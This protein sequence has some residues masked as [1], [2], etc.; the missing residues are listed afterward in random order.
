[1][2]KFFGYDFEGCFL[3]IAEENQQ[4]T[5]LRFGKSDLCNA[6][7]RETAFLTFVAQQLSE[8]FS[9]KRK[10]FD[11]PL[12]LEGTDFQ[13]KVW[14]ALLSIPYGETCSYKQIAEKVGC[15]KGC[16]A[17]GMA[18]NKNPIGIIIPCHR[19]VGADG[20]L[21]GYAGG[22]NMKQKLL[23]LERKYK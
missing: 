22:L 14:K 5:D 23:M 9:G 18:N 6:E 10:V 7:N 3:T 13:M 21:T 11:V 1:M 12:A 2:K 4:L 17:V 15:P 19:V 8:Y 16:R 20:G